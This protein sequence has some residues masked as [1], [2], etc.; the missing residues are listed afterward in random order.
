LR[1]RSEKGHPDQPLL[2]ATQEK[3]VVR[4]ERYGKR[5]V[6]A[7]KDLHLLKLVK[8]RDFV[9]TSGHSKVEL[10]MPENRA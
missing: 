4:K 3:G 1:E 8:K 7:Q 9:I 5:T 2:A 10:N 6:L